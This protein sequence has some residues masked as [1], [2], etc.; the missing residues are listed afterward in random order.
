VSFLL[1]SDIKLLFY[2]YCAFTLAVTSTLGS[3]IWNAGAGQVEDV[4]VPFGFTDSLNGI[5]YL[6]NDGAMA[7]CCAFV[8]IDRLPVGIAVHVIHVLQFYLTTFAM[9]F[10]K[11]SAC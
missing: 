11:K 9:F 2:A 1:K 7:S 6:L 8:T 3:N 10:G 4:S 5:I